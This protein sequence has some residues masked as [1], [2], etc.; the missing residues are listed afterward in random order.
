MGADNNAMLG[1]S[2]AQLLN[3]IVE[4]F[5]AFGYKNNKNNRRK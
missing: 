1:I 4:S 5:C 2:Y 3:L